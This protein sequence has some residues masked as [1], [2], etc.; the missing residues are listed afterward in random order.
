MERSNSRS[1]RCTVHNSIGICKVYS[2]SLAMSSCSIEDHAGR[3]GHLLAFLENAVG[4]G[5]IYFSLTV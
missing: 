4:L 2:C 3:P 1:S 5:V